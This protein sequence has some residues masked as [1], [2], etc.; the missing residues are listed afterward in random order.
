M[1]HAEPRR[2]TVIVPCFDRPDDLAVL[3]DDLA[4]IKTDGL[5][6]RVLVIDNGSSQPLSAPASHPLDVR[7]LRLSVNTGGSGGYNA[8]MAFALLADGSDPELL[9]LVD[10]DARVEPDTLSEL[11]ASLDRHEDLFAVGPVLCDPVSGEAHEAGGLVRRSTGTMGPAM[12]SAPDELLRCD[13]AAACCLLVRAHAVRTGGVFPP[14]FLNGD[15]SAWCLRLANFTG[16]AVGIEPRA[17]A[18]HPRFDG[19]PTFARYYAARNAFEPMAALGLGPWTRFRRGMIESTRAVNLAMTGRQDLAE[20]HLAGL[21]DAARSRVSGKGHPPP[22]EPFTELPDHTESLPRIEPT[23]SPPSA[24]HAMLGVLKRAIVGL[25]RAAAIVPAKGHPSTWLCARTVYLEHNGKAVKREIK[26]LRVLA[27]ALWTMCRGEMLAARIAL[28]PPQCTDLLPVEVALAC[29][30]R[31]PDRSAPTPRLSVIVLSFNRKEA[32][33]ETLSQLA[34]GDATREAEVIVVDNASTDGSVEA[35]REHSP[36]VRV[37]ANAHNELIEG[38]N[39]GCRAA[40][41]DLVLILDDDARPDQSSLGEAIQLLSDRP[42]LGAATFGPVHPA[43]GVGEWPFV[44]SLNSRVDDWPVMGCCN[45]VRRELWLALGGYDARFG[46]Y[47][48]DVDLAM[49]LLSMGM[50]GGVAF[51][52]RWECAHDSPAAAHKSVRWCE[53]ATRNWIWVCR[54]HGSWCL[55]ALAACLGWVGAHRHS[56]LRLRAQ[57][58]VLRGAAEGWTSLPKMP[59]WWRRDDR[60][61]ARLLAL[62]L[63]RPSVGREEFKK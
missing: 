54:R 31:E 27:W 60:V 25:P 24:L 42:E 1:S 2:I 36:R 3:L 53:Q 10:S 50:G 61:L 5:D 14:I 12:T 47:R 63:G 35:V 58:A 9:W 39:I 17:R 33:L 40:Q 52:P 20:L 55:G 34:A 16:Q 62:R 45:L 7:T 38:F 32:L 18:A 13:Y 8:G 15:D 29:A 11:I 46:L 22:F 21:R 44:T 19:F 6:V 23:T 30:P 4:S 43:T 28:F 48:N 57:L 59:R 56:G 49:R 51:D 37:I 26:R 41:G